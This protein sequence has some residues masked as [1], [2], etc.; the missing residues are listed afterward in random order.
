M[1]KIKFYIFVG[2]IA[3][4]FPTFLFS[5]R[6]SFTSDQVS[7]CD[8][9]KDAEPY[10]VDNY[11]KLYAVYES[12][13]SKNP[14]IYIYLKSPSGCRVLLSTQGSSVNFIKNSTKKFPDVEALWHMSGSESYSTYYTWNG[15]KYVSRQSNESERLNKEALEYYKKDNI[16]QA[17]KIWEKAKDLAIIPGLGFTSN[18][19]VLNN[20]GYAYYKLAK[21][22]KSD[23]HYRLALYYLDASIQVDYNRWEAHLNLGDLYSERGSLDYALQS[24]EKVLE[25]NPNYKYADKIREKIVVIREKLK[26]KTN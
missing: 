14:F 15:E 19:E 17:I 3:F 7:A 4:I 24:Y 5:N 13:G 22:T 16:E 26:D 20:L 9:I 11:N 6:I 25:L 12:N 18:A 2:F 21:K 23:E 1:L 10:I 8:E